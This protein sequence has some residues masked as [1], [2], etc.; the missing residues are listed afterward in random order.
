MNCKFCDKE[1]LPHRKTQMY[2][3]PQCGVV[4][5]KITN[6]GGYWATPISY[7][8]RKG[9]ANL[10]RSSKTK[11]KLKKYCSSSCAAMVNNATR[12]KRVLK[13]KFCNFCS[14]KLERKDYTDRRISCDSCLQQL[15]KINIEANRPISKSSLYF[16]EG[17][18]KTKQSKAYILSCKYCT[19]DFT[20]NTG[21][22]AYC[23]NEC[24]NIG[25]SNKLSLIDWESY[26][27]GEIKG[28]GN[29]NYKSR[30][31]YVRNLAR[32]KYLASTKK[33]SCIICD[34]DYH[35]D[36]CHVKDVNKYT[37]D[38]LI[39][40]I[41]HIDNLIALCKNHHYEFDR[42]HTSVTLDSGVII[43]K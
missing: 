36:V 20:H 28:D 9:C 31:P 43:Q 39:S 19:K 10:F 16:E 40:E 6:G 37:N 42:G 17:T 8:S 18:L 5:S 41:N 7:C 27:L 1:F 24:R 35:F 12:P 21:N 34:Y 25:K 14:E 38:A 13:D 22:K 29:S 33:Q 26:S 4:G 2:C 3:S 30:L 15:R 32:K 11:G 23:S